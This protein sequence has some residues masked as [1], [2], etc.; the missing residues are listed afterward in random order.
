MRSRRAAIV[1]LTIL[2]LS[3]LGARPATAGGPTSVLLVAPDTGRTASLHHSD[4][5]Y[6]KL[7]EL[8]DAFG[9][10]SVGAGEGP[11]TEHEQ[12]PFISLTWMAHDVAVWRVDHVFLDAPG[13]PWIS[14]QTD[15]SGSGNV[16]GSPA[17]WHKAADGE[18][19]AGLLDRLGVGPGAKARTQP[20]ATPSAVAAPPRSAGT[21]TSPPPAGT[22][23]RAWGAAGLALGAALTLAGF[24]A[25]RLV[26]GRT[27]TARRTPTR[28]APTT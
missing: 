7:A 13:G 6:Q 12:K 10:D 2:L 3:L 5:D 18:D 14:T 17:R 16:G 27:S 21:V 20:S 28:T 1:V 19:L 9:S 23:G 26:R 24:G 4:G 22:D 25:S 8:V 11:G 15:V